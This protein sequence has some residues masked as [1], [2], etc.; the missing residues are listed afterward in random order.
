MT[1]I[2]KTYNNDGTVT[3][4]TETSTKEYRVTYE[5]GILFERGKIISTSVKDKARK[6]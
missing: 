5:P 1:K 3:K 4:K 2:T 6:S